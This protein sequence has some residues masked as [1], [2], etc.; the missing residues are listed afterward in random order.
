MQQLIHTALTLCIAAFGVYLVLYSAGLVKRPPGQALGL[1]IRGLIKGVFQLIII[2]LKGTFEFTRALVRGAEKIPDLYGS[3]TFLTGL[4]RWRLAH[5]FRGGLCID[6]RNRISVEA[7]YRHAAIIAPSGAGKT[8]T[9]ILPNLLRLKTSALTLDPSGELSENSAGWLASQGFVVKRL[10]VAEPADS[11]CFNP[12]YRANT[13]S[14]LQQVAEI[15]VYAAYPDPRGGQRYWNDGARAILTILLRL[16]K[17]TDPRFH[18][19][20]NL[21]FLLNHF[22]QDGAALSD[23]VSRT[24]DPATRAEWEGFLAQDKRTIQGILSGAKT[25][26]G[27]FADP[28][29]CEL[30]DTE[31]LHFEDLRRRKTIIYITVPEHRIGYYQFFLTLLYTQVLSFCMEQPAPG[32]PYLPIYFFLDEFGNSGRIPGFSTIATSIR[33]R[34][35]SISIVLQDIAQVEHVYGRS[36][37]S[38]ILNGATSSRIFMPGLSLATCLEVERMLG[39][40]TIQ[41][42]E[43]HEAGRALLTADEVRTLRDDEALYLYA[44]KRPI[45]LRM[46]PYYRIRRLRRRAAVPP[47]PSAPPTPTEGEGSPPPLLQLE[48]ESPVEPE[49]W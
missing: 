38:T 21:R 26:L 40:Q 35:C 13:A 1:M 33:K 45:R 22:G 25:A 2:L 16:L 8:S 9:Y 11:L 49:D 32:E 24:A 29:L 3:A 28:A 23:F 48:P 10:N 20:R 27:K 34:Q 41:L 44:N 47:P 6:G 14:E 43:H 17:Q 4:G 15:L 5:P 37:A 7:S 18:T 31:T 19:L 12:L 42:D 36:D 39:R 46:K 30:T